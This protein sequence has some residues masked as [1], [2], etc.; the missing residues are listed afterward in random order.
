MT[1]PTFINIKQHIRA[2]AGEFLRIFTKRLDTGCNIVRLFSGFGIQLSAPALSRC[3]HYVCSVV[4][5]VLGKLT[6]VLRIRQ[7]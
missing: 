1:Y 3:T 5:A 7:N 4:S 2:K 6:E